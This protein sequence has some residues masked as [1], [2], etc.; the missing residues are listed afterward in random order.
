M[1]TAQSQ[2]VSV[3]SVDEPAFKQGAVRTFMALLLAHAMVDCLGGMWPV[4]KKM[5]GL[6]L[7]WAGLISTVAATTTMA[8][9]P[10]F[11]IWADS[12]GKRRHYILLGLLLTST[13][14]LLGPIGMHQES[15]GVVGAYVIMFALLFTTR[16]GQAMFHP[17]AAGLAGDAIA[18][19][20]SLLVSLFIGVGMMGFASSQTIFSYVYTNYAG[21]THWILAIAFPL[22]IWVWYW[23]KPLEQ[24]AVK[25]SNGLHFREALT[26]LRQHLLPLY[27]LLVFAAGQ[28][29][30]MYFLLPE[31]LESKGYPQWFVN[32][33]GFAF[34]V[35]GSVLLMVPAGYLAD[36]LGRKLLLVVTLLIAIVLY[37][38]MI[39][40]PTLPLPSFAIL[41]LF[42]GGL[43]GTVNPM[44]V[45]LGQE[46][47][48]GKASLASGILMGLA[49]SLGSQTLWISGA[50]ADYTSPA[51]ALLILGV[52]NFGG[53]ALCMFIRKPV[54]SSNA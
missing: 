25:Q 42:T 51:T 38:T 24:K 33:G 11:G 44:G 14:M 26:V 45:A 41:L 29:M 15:F 36:R 49:W 3:T 34:A 20:R 18:H 37:Y 27:G 32:G 12:G 23:C 13:G 22:M 47:L 19:K 6:D 8:M 2:S 17:P 9:Q 5:A 53:L 35:G 43:M 40:I 50:I 10:M 39:L 7:R 46:I 48:P 30:A 31:L 16:L 21:N 28:N 4:F 52:L 1:T 54:S